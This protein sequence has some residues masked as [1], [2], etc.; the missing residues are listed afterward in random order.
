MK[1]ELILEGGGMRGAYTCGVLDYFLEKGIYFKNIIAVSAGV[2]NAM[3][4]VSKQKGIGIDIITKFGSDKR[5]LSLE[6]FF[7]RGSIF[8]LDFI[9]KEIPNKIYP[10]DYDAFNNSDCE[11]IAVST[12]INTGKPHYEVIDKLN[13]KLDYAIASASL[14]L[15]SR[16]V[17]IDGLELLDG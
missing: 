15:V 3:Y 14:P 13:D 10:F 12:N 17:K 9:F 7:R 4:Y 5:Y 2:A 11:L 6:N 8:G 16:V 1:V